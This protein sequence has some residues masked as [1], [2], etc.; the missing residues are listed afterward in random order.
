MMIDI[1]T[2]PCWLQDYPTYDHFNETGEIPPAAL[3]P[4]FEAISDV[5]RVVA[6]AFWA[7]D[8]RIEVSNAFVAEVVRHDPAKIV[9]FASVD[10]KLPGAISELNKAIAE[11][12]LQGLKLGPIYQHFVPDDRAYWPLYERVQE[13]DIPIMWHQGTSFMV[14]EGPLEASPP[15]RLDII[16]RTFPNIKMVIA[17]F[18]YPW[19]REVVALLR[20]HP[21]VYTDISVLASRPW[22]LYNAL[23]DALEYGA[24]DKIL[25]GSDYPA[26]TARQTVDALRK[27]NDFA[28]GTSLPTV[29]QNIIDEIIER[30]SL[31]LLGIPT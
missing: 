24:Q 26:F 9:G 16:A 1:H 23:I 29:P 20:R 5:D 17:H 25:L 11:L 22:F 3:E 13:L 31:A 30:D 19:P 4:Y 10:P 15:H 6:L 27:I 21:H 14:P 28:R 8:S 2:H 12:G 7:P 18:G